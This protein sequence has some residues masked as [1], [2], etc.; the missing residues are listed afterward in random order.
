VKNEG[1]L[2]PLAKN[3]KAC[4]VE[5]VESH[6]GQEGDQF[7]EQVRQA[8]PG[9]TLFSIAPEDAKTTSDAILQSP[10]DV[11]VVGAWVS[12][13]GYRGTATL[14]G[15]FPDLLNSIIATNKPVILISLGN[16]YIVRSFAGVKAYM[17]TYSTVQTSETAAVK[18]L[19]GLI[20]INGRLP[21][22]IPGIAA[23]HWGLRVGQ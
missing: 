13:A 10:C 18:A 14:G 4:F 19:F 2:I 12:V 11:F 23:Y 22:T 1:N 17:T 5:M 8:A 15:D 7:T 21:V 9:S 20:P 16:P 6:R 3:R